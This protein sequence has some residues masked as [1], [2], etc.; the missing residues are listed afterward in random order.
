MNQTF[1]RVSKKAAA[2]V[3]L[4]FGSAIRQADHAKLSRHIVAL[5]KKNSALDIINELSACLKD[6]L[7]YRLFAFAVKKDGRV[8]VWLD[9][10]MYKKS[11]EGVIAQD[12][13]LPHPKNLTFINHEFAPHEIQEKFSIDHLEY[14]EID[15]EDF[16][17]RLYMLPEHRLYPFHDEVVNLMLQGC[18]AALSKQVRIENLKN[19]ATLDPLTQCYNRREFE[20]QLNRHISNAKRHQYELS[21][22]MFDLDHFK[23]VNDTYGHLA[24]DMVLREVSALVR[25]SM[26]QGDILCRYGGEEFIAILP[27]TDKTKA[28]ELADRLREK[29][30]RLPLTYENRRINV[31]S[32]FGVSGLLSEHDMTSFVQDADAMLYKA[33]LNGRNRVMPGL[34]KVCSEQDCPNGTRMKENA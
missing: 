26:R 34:I 7:G 23:K 28:I 30:S 10:R 8:E 33:K 14:Y 31:T 17:A 15:E 2:L 20:S 27:E 18:A 29:I 22:I 12:F 13:N 4:I 9:P 16:Q 32:S 11:I 6:I 3:T 25:E 21:L 5:S 19:A 24:G 1:E